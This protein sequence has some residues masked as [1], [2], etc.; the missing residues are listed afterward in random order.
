[1]LHIHCS[2]HISSTA[3]V[4]IGNAIAM[5]ARW[6]FS[7]Q[8][9]TCT[10]LASIVTT[11]DN[12]FLVWGSRPIIRSPLARFLNQ[13][14]GSRDRSSTTG[15]SKTRSS[16][17]GSQKER[18]NSL[19]RQE[20]DVFEDENL[21]QVGSA[22]LSPTSIDLGTSSQSISSGHLASNEASPERKPSLDGSIAAN[23]TPPKDPSNESLNQSHPKFAVGTTSGLS[24]EQQ[25]V[26]GHM[27]IRRYSSLNLSDTPHIMHPCSSSKE[28]MEKVNNLLQELGLLSDADRNYRGVASPVS[29]HKE[30]SDSKEQGQPVGGS[31]FKANKRIYSSN[32]SELVMLDGIVMKPTSIDL[33]GRSGLLSTLSVQGLTSAKLEGVSCFG[34]NVLI[35]IEAQVMLDAEGKDGT[36]QRVSTASKMTK[37]PRLVLGRKLTEKGALRRYT[38]Q[39]RFLPVFYGLCLRE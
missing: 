33:V 27:N 19:R 29:R 20:S 8:T 38:K 23:K 2:N 36:Q 4:S 6:Y 17:S 15:D 24:K 11:E 18:S 32:S 13:H 7:L 21:P 26:G 12:S 9:V 14:S 10:E 31:G 22:L 16:D 34:C 39:F 35:L 28:Y 30:I 37:Q 1:M 5:H 3:N 25:A